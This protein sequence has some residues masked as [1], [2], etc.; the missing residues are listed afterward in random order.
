MGNLID[1]SEAFRIGSPEIDAHHHVLVGILNELHHAIHERKGR[2]ACRRILKRLAHLAEV[3]FAVEES[4]MVLFHHPEYQAHKAEH[5]RLIAEVGE[6]LDAIE[7]YGRGVSFHRLHRLRLWFVQHIRMASEICAGQTSP[8]E[9]EW[10]KAYRG[11]V[12]RLGR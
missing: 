3:H 1:W 4:L 10:R 5:A 12:Q 6:M 11:R 8:S 7:R 9:V 2:T